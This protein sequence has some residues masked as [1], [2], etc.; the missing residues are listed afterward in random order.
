MAEGQMAKVPQMES[1][2]LGQESFCSHSLAH[3]KRLTSLACQ[4]LPYLQEG[5]RA[6][7]CVLPRNLLSQRQKDL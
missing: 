7:A 5:E 4:M 2:L 6:Q 1:M 3:T